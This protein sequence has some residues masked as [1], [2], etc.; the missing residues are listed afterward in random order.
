MTTKHRFSITDT[1]PKHRQRGLTS[2]APLSAGLN[3]NTLVAT[4][5][6]PRG[7]YPVARTLKNAPRPTRNKFQSRLEPRSS[8]TL[9]GIKIFRGAR[10]D[11]DFFPGELD[12]LAPG[13]MWGRKMDPKIV[14]KTSR[15]N[16]TWNGAIGPKK[17]SVSPPTNG[18]SASHQM[19]ICSDGSLVL[20]GVSRAGTQ[21]SDSA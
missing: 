17:Y 15:Q 2:I 16:V 9:L 20:T 21:H 12:E 1:D 5:C 11:C 18:A 14:Q 8:V 4:N 7:T 19:C 6:N 3:P 10:K 13:R